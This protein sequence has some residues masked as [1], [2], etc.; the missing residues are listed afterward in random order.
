MLLGVM[1]PNGSTNRQLCCLGENL[2]F[3]CRFIMLA[4]H[5]VCGDVFVGWKDQKIV[6]TREAANSR[7]GVCVLF[8]K[9][10]AQKS[11]PHLGRC[12]AA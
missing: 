4:Y 12:N 1:M 2:V 7:M 11:N 6:F 9:R 10:K 3:V 5:G 8:L